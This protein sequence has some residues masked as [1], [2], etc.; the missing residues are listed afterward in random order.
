MIA[1]EEKKEESPNAWQNF[2]RDVR[3]HVFPFFLNTKQ[4][5][6]LNLWKYHLEEFRSHLHTVKTMKG[7]K[8]IAYTTKNNIFSSLNGFLKTM[9]RHHY[10]EY[11]LKVRR[12]PESLTNKKTADAVIDPEMANRIYDGL[13]FKLK[14]AAEFFWVLLHTGMRLNEGIGL[15]MADFYGHDVESD[16]MMKALNPYK[17][18]PIG[19]I[20]LESQPKHRN[21]TRNQKGIVERKPLK[22][23]KKID[24]ENARIIPIFNKKAYN[25][26]AIRWNEQQQ[27][28]QNRKF[29]PDLKNYLLFDGLRASTFSRLFKEVQKDMRL[30]FL[31]T[32]HDTRHTYSTWLVDQTAGN[33]TLCRM[34]LGHSDLDMTMRYVHI[35]A[36]LRRQLEMKY[37]TEKPLELVR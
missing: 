1:I 13:S 29:G 18:K 20:A 23:K 2:E 10:L 34:I 33:Y 32:P 14:S 21:E 12:F 19:C 11:E 15:S 7:Q 37:Q 16:F 28:Y 36:K 35:N 30:S 9:Y 27:H 22:S 17:L 6:N 25:I 4:Q 31:H 8:P 5:P 24:P 26:L 3:L